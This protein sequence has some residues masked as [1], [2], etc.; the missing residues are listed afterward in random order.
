MTDGIFR[1]QATGELALQRAP[2]FKSLQDIQYLLPGNRTERAHRPALKRQP[3][4][5]RVLRA[6]LVVPVCA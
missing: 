6:Q 1:K 4:L 2:R 3:T 5:L